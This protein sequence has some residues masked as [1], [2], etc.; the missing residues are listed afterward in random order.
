VQ[1][2]NNDFEAYRRCQYFA[3]DEDGGVLEL[4]QY[5]ND[6]SNGATRDMDP[7]EYWQVRLIIQL[8]TFYFLML[9][10]R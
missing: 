10:L 8:L 3:S 6:R 2:F 7:V 9:F 5:L 1:D 4:R